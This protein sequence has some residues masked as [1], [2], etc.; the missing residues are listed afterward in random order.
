MKS[1]HILSDFIL[2]LG[3]FQTEHTE[4][5]T[6]WLHFFYEGDSQLFGL[7]QQ[8]NGFGLGKSYIISRLSSRS[9]SIVLRLEQ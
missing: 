3:L 8:K 5:D 6:V 7:S 4:N 1:K 9:S 2:L